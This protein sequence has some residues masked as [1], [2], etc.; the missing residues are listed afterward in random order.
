MSKDKLN[1]PQYNDLIG[2]ILKKHTADGGMDNLKGAGKPLSKEYFSGDTFQ[3]FQRI[4]Q[5]AGYKPHWLKL[6]HEIRD[7]LLSVIDLIT[8]RTDSEIN[9]LIININ[10]KISEYNKACPPPLQKGQVSQQN[11][12]AASEHW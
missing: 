10:E 5:D 11:I 4:A 7:D 2:D 6:R 8:L 9:E 3:H 1:P 12:K